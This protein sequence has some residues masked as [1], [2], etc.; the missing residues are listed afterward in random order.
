MGIPRDSAEEDEEDEEDM[1]SGGEGE[2]ED[3]REEEEEE[4]EGGE[5][6]EG[7]EGREEDN[8]R[9]AAGTSKGRVCAEGG[10]AS[11]Q[12]KL[13]L[14]AYWSLSTLTRAVG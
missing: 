12:N 4:G 5:A 11:A 3:E 7:K 9:V 1:E 14:V 8:D 13:D 6:Q 10:V 2:E